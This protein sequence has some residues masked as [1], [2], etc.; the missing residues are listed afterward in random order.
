MFAIELILCIMPT[1]VAGYFRK[2]LFVLI[3]S[4]VCLIG[5]CEFSLYAQDNPYGIDN[6]CFEQFWLTERKIGSI[7][8][9]S[10]LNELMSMSVKSSDRKA[11][12][13]AYVLKLRDAIDRKDEVDVD[14][15]LSGLLVT[16]ESAEL[17]QYYYHGYVLAASFYNNIGMTTK[18]LAL[19]QEMETVSKMNADVY[20]RWSSDRC[21]ASLYI[22]R[23]NNKAAREYLLEAIDIFR[24]T[25][26]H[27]LSN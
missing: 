21:L 6:D 15:S 23:H 25:K 7:D 27:I 12:T 3:T 1:G 10:S 4:L 24:S 20:G 2:L 17:S 11:L 5:L 19:A 14:E 9:A 13:L 22:A 16:A 26:S 8:F 18:S